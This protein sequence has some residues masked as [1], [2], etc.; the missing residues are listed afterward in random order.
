MG[1]GG[2]QERGL[3][4]PERD[5]TGQPGRVVDQRGAVLADRPHHRTPPGAEIG[6]HRGH[7]LAELADPADRPTRLPAP[8]ARPAGVSP[9]WS[10]TTSAAGTASARSATAA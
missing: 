8:T 9:H 1:G 3:V 4:D 2:G 7:R 6:G 10:P 5:H